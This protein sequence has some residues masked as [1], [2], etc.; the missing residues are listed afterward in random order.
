M[1][2]EVKYAVSGKQTTRGKYKNAIPILFPTAD[3]I[4]NEVFIDTPYPTNRKNILDPFS[5]KNTSREDCTF[6]FR[7]EDSLYSL[8]IT[9]VPFSS[10]L[11]VDLTTP[12]ALNQVGFRLYKTTPTSQDAHQYGIQPLVERPP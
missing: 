7:V 11:F 2:T 9:L 5:A 12:E 3:S 1:C 8:T 10:T 6:F 4:S